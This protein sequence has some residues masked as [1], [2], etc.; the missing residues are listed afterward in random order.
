MPKKKPPEIAR[1]SR[2]MP[3]SNMGEWD[4]TR[5]GPLYVPV[6][7]LNDWVHSNILRDGA[8]LHNPDHDHLFHADIGYLWAGEPNK[9]KM[10]QII[11]QTEELVFR[12]GRWQRGRQEQQLSEWFGRVPGWLITL[13][14]S[15]CASCTDAE[16]CALLEHEL[17]HIGH[18]L[19]D[20]GSPRFTQEGLPKLAMRGHDVEEFI[21]VVR[22][23][24]IGRSDG[25]LARLIDASNAAPEIAKLN[26][27]R[28]CGTCLARAA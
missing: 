4:G 10:R 8:P 15:Y 21:G 7:A 17:Y 9:S 11:G 1:A 14:A 13:D 24:G 23:Y 2:P 27:A 25:A 6:P 3:P 18:D 22:R 5:W 20:F 16:F 19:D 26:V 12:V 28:A